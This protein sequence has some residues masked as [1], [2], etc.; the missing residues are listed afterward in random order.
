[1][2]I[3]FNITE[4]PEPVA[5]CLQNPDFDMADCLNVA[6]YAQY[7]KVPLFIIETPYDAYSVVNIVGALC[8]V[9]KDSPYSLQNCNSAERAAIEDYRLK[10]I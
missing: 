2:E 6:N 8:P 7:I 4:T 10:S 5:K 9:N 1:M 3:V